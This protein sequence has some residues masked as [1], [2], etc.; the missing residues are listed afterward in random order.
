ME[1]RLIALYEYAEQQGI[2]VDWFS[3][4]QV[5][6][7]SLP[8]PDGTCCIAIDP[9]KMETVEQ[10][11]VALAH[12]LGHC[13]TGSFYNRYAKLDLIQKH[14]NRADRWAYKKLVPKDELMNAWLAGYQEIWELAEYF[15]LPEDFL[16]G[17]IEYYKICA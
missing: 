2:D 11:T 4:S 16:R 1:N 15:R 14:E 5:T 12:E 10:E 7:M 9:W 17:A 6:S 13:E 3:A 8:L